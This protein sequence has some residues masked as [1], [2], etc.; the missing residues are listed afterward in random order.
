MEIKCNYTDCK[1]LFQLS[2]DAGRYCVFW[3]YLSHSWSGAGCEVDTASSTLT[4]TVCR[5][6]AGLT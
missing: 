4:R 2:Q 3:D 6:V 1:S 5:W